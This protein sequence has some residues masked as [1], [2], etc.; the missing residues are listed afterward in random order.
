MSL[1]VG[2]LLQTRYRIVALHGQGGMSAVYL[3][4]DTVKVDVYATN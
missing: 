1:V 3:A 4:E 2:Q